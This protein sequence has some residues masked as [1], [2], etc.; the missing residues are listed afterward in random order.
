[1]AALKRIQGGGSR[2]TQ[3]PAQ[4]SS[5]G[6]KQAALAA[7]SALQ[8]AKRTEFRAMMHQF[9]LDLGV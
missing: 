7:N 1:M 2:I 5:M 3:P 8:K 9:K 4:M 6:Q